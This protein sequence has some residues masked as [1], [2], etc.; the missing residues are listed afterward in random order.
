MGKTNAQLV[1]YAKAQLGK[2]YW[3]GT[4][5]QTATETLLEQKASQYP[6]MYTK[7]RIAKARKEHLGQRVHDCMGLVKGFLWSKDEGSSPRYKSSEDW[8]ADATFEKATEKGP[9]ATIPEIPGILVRYKGHVGIYIGGGKVIEARGFD[10]GVVSTR[11]EDRKWLHWYKHPLIEYAEEVK[12]EKP[13][14]AGTSEQTYK[15][16]SGDTLSKIARNYKTTVKALADLNNIEN[17]DL[18]RTGQILRIPGS[19]VSLPKTANGIVATKA[20]NLNIRAEASTNSKILGTLPK[21]THVTV[22]SEQRGEFYKLADR[23]G[24]VAAKFIKL[25]I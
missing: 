14:K 19:S 23:D 8:S 6:K 10:Y 1:A 25:D 21:G 13:P 20:D 7:S 24:F 17:P 11:L 22:E 2:P 18:I 5:G 9:I 15:V 12:P 16:K 3:F 4:F